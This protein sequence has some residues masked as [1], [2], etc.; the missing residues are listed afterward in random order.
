M[1]RW[2]VIEKSPQRIVTEEK[3]GESSNLISGILMFL[4]CCVPG[5]VALWMGIPNLPKILSCK[6]SGSISQCQEVQKFL[7]IP[8]KTRSF[9]QP[10]KISAPIVRELG[11]NITVVSVGLAYIGGIVGIVIIYS[12]MVVGRRVWVF[13]RNRQVI[14]NEKYTALRKTEQRYRQ[15]DVFGIILEINDFYINANP[16]HIFVRLNLQSGEQPIRYLPFN[17]QQPIIYDCEYSTLAEAIDT[18]I[19]PTSKVLQVPYQLK[20]FFQQQACSIFDFDRQY[21]DVFADQDSYQI[22]FTDIQRFE[23]EKISDNQSIVSIGENS[24]HTDAHH[25]YT[26]RLLLITNDGECLP[27]HQVESNDSSIRHERAEELLSLTNNQ[28]YRWMELL[29]QELEQ[30]MNLVMV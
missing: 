13:D 6:P 5:F 17:S 14:V 28:G 20:F 2:S 12:S 27:I 8:I 1:N 19:R 25:S 9:V 29:Q 24:L 11:G 10:Q 15:Q 23:I 7:N 4:L 16:E 30:L 18:V 22:P 3:L 26:Y 21:I